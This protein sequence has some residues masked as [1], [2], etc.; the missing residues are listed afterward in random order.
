MVRRIR[1]H[2]HAF[3]ESEPGN[4]FQD[5]YERSVLKRGQ[6]SQLSKIIHVLIGLVIMVLGALLW[7]LP[8]PGWAVVFIGA[9][10]IAG[11]SLWMA[12][13]LDFIEVKVRKW[14]RDRKSG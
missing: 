6:R 1:E 7:F 2:W 4:R 9:A 13:F 12:R 8:G 14:G 10:V 3:K 5:R 11:E